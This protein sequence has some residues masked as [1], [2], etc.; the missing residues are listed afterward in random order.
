MTI[1]KLNQEYYFHDSIL[2]RIEYQ[3]KELKMYCTFCDFMQSGYDKSE[4][5]NSDIVVVFYHASYEI[6]DGFRIE[7]SSFLNQELHDSKIVFFMEN[8]SNEFGHLIIKADSVEV[9]KIRSYN[10]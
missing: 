6:T 5:A 2:E 7:S 3:H 8:A 4:Y 10:L 9:I 1:K